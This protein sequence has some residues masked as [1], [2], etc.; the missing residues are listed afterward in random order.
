MQV[1]VLL[2]AK[3]HRKLSLSKQFYKTSHF[4]S[5][6]RTRK[7]LIYNIHWICTVGKVASRTC[8]GVGMM[9]CW[10]CPW[11]EDMTC[12]GIGGGD[13]IG[14]TDGNSS[15]LPGGPDDQC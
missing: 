15:I 1:K 11:L 9:S 3:M 10:C 14:G 13:T 7:I 4:K 12:S 5:D 6:G 8:G 2:L